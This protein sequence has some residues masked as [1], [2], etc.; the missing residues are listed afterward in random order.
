MDFSRRQVKLRD[1][2]WRDATIGLHGEYL[3]PL[4]EPDQPFDFQRSVDLDFD[5]TG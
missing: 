3:L 5:L 2:P 1:A 4:W